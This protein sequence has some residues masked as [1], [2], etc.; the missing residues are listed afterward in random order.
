MAEALDSAL[1]TPAGTT[2]RGSFVSTIVAGHAL[3]HLMISGLSS[4]LIPEI[5]LSMSLSATQV[6]TLGSVQQFSGWFATLGAGYL[7]DRFTYKTGLMLAFSLGLT[8]FGM[9]LVGLSP[10]YGALVVAMLFTGL[11]PSMFHPPAVGALSRRFP[12]RRAFAISMHGTGGSIGEV[13]GPV[14]VAGMLALL[15]WRDVL[16]VLFLPAM[17]AAILTWRLLQEPANHDEDG[18]LTL[19]SYF[20]SFRELLGQR[21]LLLILLV[22]G[23]RTVG[24]ATTAV[25]LPIYL[26]EDLGYSAGLVGL[27]ISMSQ[28]A[29]IGSQPL[30]GSLTDRLGHKAVLVPALIGFSVLLLLVPVADGKLQLAIVVLALGAFLFSLQSVL[31]SAA[32]EVAGP[33]VHSTV[34]S[35]IYASS[36]VGSLAPALAGVLADAYGLWSTFVFSFSLGMVSVAVLMLTR[37]PKRSARPIHV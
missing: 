20:S 7:G 13:L 26:R 33:N 16:F 9:L 24:Q 30:M 2:G 19:G 6:G 23:L 35:L 5:K 22:T 37:L 27:F 12:D 29:G 15:F 1:V 25:F 32:I 34:V 14:T 10:G 11:G 28:L 36:F 8:G 18:H 31:T 4:V 17:V 3:K 21:A